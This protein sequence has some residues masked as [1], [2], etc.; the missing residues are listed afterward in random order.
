MRN[1]TFIFVLVLLWLLATGNFN[2]PNAVV[3]LIAALVS[4]FIIRDY[5]VA[6]RDRKNYFRHPLR[7]LYLVWI[8]VS[9]LVVGSIQIGWMLLQPRSRWAYAPGILAVPLDTRDDVE[10]TIFANMISMIPG[11]L[12]VDVSE[13]KSTLYMHVIDA[14][15][16]GDKAGS[17][18]GKLIEYVK[19]NFE[20]NVIWAMQQR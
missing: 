20:A 2:L 16:P 17:R 18:K 15:D 10:I 8:F 9:E 13:D 1:A 12:T 11:T 5:L 4:G 14:S 6:N 7:L 3:G 19:T